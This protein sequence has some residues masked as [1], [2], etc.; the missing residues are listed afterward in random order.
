MTKQILAQGLQSLS[1]IGT[2]GR[3]AS[4]NENH[5]PRSGPSEHEN[6]IVAD[7]RKVNFGKAGPVHGQYLEKFSWLH[8]WNWDN[9][10]PPPPRFSIKAPGSSAPARRLRPAVT[11]KWLA[12]VCI[13]ENNRIMLRY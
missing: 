1:L 9:D 6:L 4:G 7:N 5:R 3:I 8:P 12:G 13:D 11:K 2:A 10:R